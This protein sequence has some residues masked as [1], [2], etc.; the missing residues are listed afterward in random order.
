MYH[1]TILWRNSLSEFADDRTLFAWS[2]PILLFTDNITFHYSWKIYHSIFPGKY[3]SIP[4]IFTIPSFLESIPFHHSWNVYHSIIPGKYT[5]PSFLVCIPTFLENMPFHHSGK[6]T[7]PSFL[8]DISYVWYTSSLFAHSKS[9]RCGILS[10]SNVAITRSHVHGV[11][12][13]YHALAAIMTG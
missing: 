5:I 4:G 3:T 13:R 8:E 12:L 1:F 7:I 6:Y 9:C 10:R 11:C 2:Y